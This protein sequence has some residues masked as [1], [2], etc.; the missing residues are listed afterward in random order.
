M[1]YLRVSFI[2]GLIV[3]LPI[4]I[5]GLVFYYIYQF[6]T[7]VFVPL[8]DQ[9]GLSTAELQIIA[10]VLVIPVFILVCV[11]LGILV[12]TGPGE[13]IFGFIE[14]HILQRIPGYAIV[15]RLFRGFA[16]GEDGYPAALCA[17][18]GQDD[19]LTPA[20]VMEDTGKDTGQATG[21]ATG[22][23][24]LTVFV[25]FAPFMTAGTVHV[26]P[27]SRVQVLDKSTVS[28]ANAVGQWGI[29]LQDVIDKRA[30]SE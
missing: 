21:K 19:V 17:L 13:A 12:R 24:R 30:S 18:S 4:A 23:D 26:L 1:T 5:L 10:A 9:V 2:Y 3:L 27:R 6:W 20:F 16:D 28:A 25:P 8:A 7:A 14:R 29:G 11:L 15:S 22:A